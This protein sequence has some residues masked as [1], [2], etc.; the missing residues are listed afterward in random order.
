MAT[1]AELAKL[2]GGEVV[3]DPQLEIQGVSGI[4]DAYPG[5]I[6]LIASAKA[7]AMARESRATAFVMPSSLPEIDQPGI[8]VN[9]PRLAFAQ[10]VEVFHPKKRPAS[11]IHPTVVVGDDCHIGDDVSIGA[12]VV[13]GHNVAIGDRVVI[14]PGVIIED[15]VVI[16][17]DTVIYPN[18]VIMDHTIIG[19]RV[20]INAGAIIGSEGFGFVTV[21]G[22]HHKVP[23]IG[24]V[25]IEDDVEIGANVTIDR[26]TLGTTRIKRGTKLDN[27]IQ[28]GHNVVLGEDNILAGMSGIAGS[29]HTGDRVTMGGQAGL[30]GHIHVG[31]DSVV[32]ARGMVINSLPPNSIVSGAPARAHSDDMRVQAAA[33]KLP[34]MLKTIRELQ[35]KLTDLEGRL[36]SK[37]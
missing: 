30:V 26:A 21:N 16:G 31:S 18:A 22:K 7:L 25:V 35:K 9:V 33:G 5:T 17:E 2:V 36:L 24:N 19:S 37:D 6:T 3:G 14:K 29:A 20:I 4:E 13:I 27:L 28:I 32:M 12:Q 15:E 10:I 23:Q 11:G 8:R 1:L 34:E